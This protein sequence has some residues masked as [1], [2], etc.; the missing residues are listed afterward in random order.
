MVLG[1]RGTQRLERL[2]AFLRI[3]QVG[4][5][6][7]HH[8]AVAQR[9]WHLGDR[10]QLEDARRRRDEVGADARAVDA[11]AAHRPRLDEDRVVEPAER[12]RVVAGRLRRHP[13]PEVARGPHDGE[14][15]VLALGERDG[16]G[17][18]V[19][20]EVPGQARV[21]PAGVARGEQSA[22]EAA[23]QVAQRA[24]VDDGIDGHSD[25]LVNAW[26]W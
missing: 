3:A 2:R 24:Q 7:H 8:L 4:A 1:T 18:L 6:D 20:V 22:A 10:R 11:H 25:L 21:V 5:V 26:S 9:L 16:G 14:H 19:G 13:E 15:V 17:V 23:A 12:G